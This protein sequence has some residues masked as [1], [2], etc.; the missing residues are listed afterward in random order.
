MFLI[1][2]NLVTLVHLEIGNFSFFQYSN[3]IGIGFLVDNLYKLDI[4]VSL[5]NE[6]LHASNFGTKHQLTDENSFMLWHKHLG[7]ISKQ[8]I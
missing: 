3:M 2:T 8:S 6:S 7:H 1:W 4:H 5:I